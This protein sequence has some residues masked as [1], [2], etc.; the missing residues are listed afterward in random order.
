MTASLAEIQSKV[1]AIADGDELLSEVHDFI[2]RFVAYPGPDCQVAHALWIAHTHL[3]E[4]WDSTPRIAFLSAEPGSGKSRALE[5][6][7]LLVPRPIEAINATPAYLF[8]KVAD[9]EG[10]PTILFD[11]IDTIFG[12]KAKHN[13]EIRG[14]L[15]AGHR[16]GAMAGRCVVRGKTVETEE[17]PAYCA[18][19]VAGI[20]NLPDTILTR[21][22]VVRMRRR[23]P[24]EKIQ[25]FRRKLEV[26]EGHELRERLAEW[27]NLIKSRVSF[28]NMPNG[29]EDR[30]AD[31]W[32]ALLAVADA[33]GGI[34]PSTARVSAVSLVTQSKESTPSIGI[35][36]LSD[37]RTIFGDRDNLPTEEA[38]TTLA[39]IEEAPWGDWKGK[40]INAR[41][42]AN[43]LKQYG[44][45]SKVIRCGE[46]TFRGYSRQDLYDP[47]MR[48]VPAPTSGVTNETN[49]TRGR[50]NGHSDSAVSDVT[51]LVEA[52]AERMQA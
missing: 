15:N 33:A 43:F 5:V 23:A 49:V 41:Q 13:E 14:V 4:V 51:C 21:S 40:P 24:N 37:L 48:Y 19:A 11:E 22:V 25:Q 44:I 31:V 38:L 35:R 3:M 45:A 47:W 17:L 52:N 18:V 39:A 2:G 46:G 30:N 16:R 36:L 26:A 1:D 50:F 12:P 32:E 7:A 29:I 6:T 8:R 42:L 27:V 28:L 34:W 10:A 20:G 9:P